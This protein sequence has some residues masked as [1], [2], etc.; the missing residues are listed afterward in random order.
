MRNIISNTYWFRDTPSYWVKASL[1]FA[2]AVACVKIVSKSSDKARR[3]YNRITEKW[4]D[5]GTKA[6]SDKIDSIIPES[7]K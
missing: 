6:V 7:G 3:F 1:P 2:Y 4:S 5:D